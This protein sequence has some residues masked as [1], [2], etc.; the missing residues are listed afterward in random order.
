LCFAILLVCGRATRCAAA[1]VEEHQQNL[2]L[3][4]K[5]LLVTAVGAGGGAYGAQG[6]ELRFCAVEVAEKWP[7]FLV[8]VPSNRLECS[9]ALFQIGF[10]L[11]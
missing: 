8:A 6:P 5:H 2:T 1:H 11:M 3:G 10:L 9:W 4:V 7:E